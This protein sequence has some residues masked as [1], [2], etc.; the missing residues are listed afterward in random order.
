MAYFG[1][2]FPKKKGQLVLEKNQQESFVYFV[3]H[4]SKELW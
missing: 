3:D 1:N 2:L 4:N